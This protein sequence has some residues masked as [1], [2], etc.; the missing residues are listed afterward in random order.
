MSMATTYS[1]GGSPIVENY[2]FIAR[3]FYYSEVDLGF[4]KNKL[5]T[6]ETEEPVTSQVNSNG[7]Y[8]VGAT[9]HMFGT[10]NVA[11]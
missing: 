4:I 8:E 9:N 3:D 7:V 2:Q 11:L 6:N 1:A 5:T 10:N